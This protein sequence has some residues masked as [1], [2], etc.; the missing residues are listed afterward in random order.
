M[1]HQFDP[2]SREKAFCCPRTWEMVS[3]I[4]NRRAGL[5]ATTERALFRGTVGEAAAVEFSAFLKVW[6]ELPHRAAGARPGGDGLPRGVLRALGGVRLYLGNGSGARPHRRRGGGVEER[7][8]RVLGRVQRRPRGDRRARS[9]HG[10]RRGRGA[11]G[12]LYLRDGRGAGAAALPG[13]RRGRSAG[14]GEPARPVRGLHRARLRRQVPHMAVAGEHPP[15][16]PEKPLDRPRLGRG[17]D[18]DDPHAAANR[19]PGPPSPPPPSG[20]ARAQ[21]GLRR[22]S[23]RSR[24]VLRSLAS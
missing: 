10:S 18:D 6:R 21:T 15:A 1:L 4:V 2:Q 19:A 8:R 12:G 3:N 9:R 20:A 5:D 16:A 23:P 17:F 11:P 14:Q 22:L 13:L 7:A 24:P